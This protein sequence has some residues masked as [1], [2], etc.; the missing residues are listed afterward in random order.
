MEPVVLTSEEI[1]ERYNTKIIKDI[2]KCTL[3]LSRVDKLLHISYAMAFIV[4][5]N[6][7]DVEAAQLTFDDLAKWIK[8]TINNEKRSESKNV[9]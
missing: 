7:D 1:S 4:A 2:I 8:I 9:Q 3:D 6:C 5:D